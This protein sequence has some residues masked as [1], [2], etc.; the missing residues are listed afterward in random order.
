MFTYMKNLVVQKHS[1]SL[2]Y[3]T[4]IGSTL[5]TTTLATVFNDRN[6]L[7]VRITRIFHLKSFLTSTMFNFAPLKNPVDFNSLIDE[8]YFSF[9]LCNFI[10]YDRQK[11][12]HLGL[13]MRSGFR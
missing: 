2:I 4:G 5:F 6:F 9:I 1:G 7:D 8:V 3:V 13:H 11:S 12:L 10:R